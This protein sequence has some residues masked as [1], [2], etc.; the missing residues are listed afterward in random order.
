MSAYNIEEKFTQEQ[1]DFLSHHKIELSEVLDATGMRSKDYRPFMREEHYKVAVGVTPCKLGHA[2]RTSG[3]NCV[4]CWPRNLGHQQNYRSSNYIY[5]F[6]SSRAGLVKIG[7]SGDV[8]RRLAEM[9]RKSTA[10]TTDWRLCFTRNVGSEAGP[11]EAE[12][13]SRLKLYRTDQVFTH[14]LDMQQS[15]EHFSCTPEEALKVLKELT[16]G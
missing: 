16:E 5:L 10:N 13:H 15:R 1:L 11:L 12:A 4:Q 3:G 14:G 2:M 9:N 8:K 7:I 6:A